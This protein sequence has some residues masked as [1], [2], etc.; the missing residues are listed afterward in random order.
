MPG[1]LPRIRVKQLLAGRGPSVSGRGGSRRRGGAGRTGRRGTGGAARRRGRAGGRAA[2]WRRR[3]LARGGR[4]RRG[5]RSRRRGGGHRCAG[6][7]GGRARRRSGHRQRPG[8][9]R[10]RRDHDSGDDCHDAPDGAG[11]QQQDG[12][13]TGWIRPGPTTCQWVPHRCWT[14][15]GHPWLWPSPQQEYRARPGQTRPGN[16][17]KP[18]VSLDV[19]PIS[20]PGRPAFPGRSPAPR[21]EIFPPGARRECAG[22]CGRPRRSLNR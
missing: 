3:G 15:R 9:W 13:G 1:K 12:P 22:R 8:G 17:R 4:R 18:D 14:V 10:R 19:M 16:D 2:G 7:R 11:R 21:E 20:P 5:R 6:G